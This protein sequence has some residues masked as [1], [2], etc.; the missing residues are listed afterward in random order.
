MQMLPLLLKRGEISIRG[1]MEAKF[2]TTTEGMAIQSLVHIKSVT[3][4]R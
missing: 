2:R 4:T 1:D 3:K